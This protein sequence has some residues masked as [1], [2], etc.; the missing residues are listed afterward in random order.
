ML[1]ENMQ[2][3]IYSEEQVSLKA[4]L[5]L[6]QWQSLAYIHIIEISGERGGAS[7]TVTEEGIAEEDAKLESANTDS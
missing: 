6:M 1:G 7:R 4:R 3:R 5:Y 2:C